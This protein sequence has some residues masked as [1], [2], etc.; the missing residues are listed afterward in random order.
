VALTLREYNYMLVGAFE[1]L[2]ARRDELTAYGESLAARR[3]AWIARSE[4][5]LAL[6]RRLPPPA[7]GDERPEAA[8][9]AEPAP[10]A[11]EG[12]EHHPHHG[13]H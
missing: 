11:P 7:A 5:E 13:G 2:G 1:L 6:G 9:E 12:H 3:D 8:P 4:L 10:P